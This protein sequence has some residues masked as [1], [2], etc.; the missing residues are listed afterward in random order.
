MEN[1]NKATARVSVQPRSQKLFIFSL[2]GITRDAQATLEHYIRKI[3]NHT[4]HLATSLTAQSKSV[5][6]AF[7]RANRFSLLRLLQKKRALRP[8]IS[9][10]L[11]F[12]R[13]TE[14]DSFPDAINNC[15]AKGC[16]IPPTGAKRTG[17]SF[18]KALLTVTLYPLKNDS[19]LW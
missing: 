12:K 15:S 11:I 9:S 8:Y 19:G 2:P 3:R 4:P 18:P 6:P 13:S 5:T 16:S 10:I 7:T 17:S 1:E 14:L